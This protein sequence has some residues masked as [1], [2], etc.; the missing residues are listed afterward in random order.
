ME[1]Q[2][3]HHAKILS[4]KNSLKETK[5]LEDIITLYTQAKISCFKNPH[6]KIDLLLPRGQNPLRYVHSIMN[7]NTISL[8]TANK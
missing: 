5:I 8:P 1:T 3:F 6:I 4:S 7:L 2:I